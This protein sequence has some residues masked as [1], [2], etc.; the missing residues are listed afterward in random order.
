MP[1]TLTVHN[2]QVTTATVEIKTLTISG[3]QVTLAVFR[4]LKEEQLIAHDG[5][6][7]GTPWGI[8]NYHPGKC[9]DPTGHVH[10]VWQN[11][12]ELRR[13]TV[14]LTTY[15]GA[16]SSEAT[17]TFLLASGHTSSNG[18]WL[19]PDWTQ[20]SWRNRDIT[21]FQIKTEDI[22]MRCEALL[23]RQDQIPDP[24]PDKKTAFIALMRELYDEDARRE[25]HSIEV[26]KINT[27]LPQLFIA[28]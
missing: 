6:L 5:T 16:Y 3:K 28:T 7:N 14:D 27:L 12:T 9:E 25:R 13:S 26:A 4:Q 8:V 20:T 21:S 18:G 2:A 15:W 10:V 24:L 1:E 11:G 17:D 23:P 19:R 22:N